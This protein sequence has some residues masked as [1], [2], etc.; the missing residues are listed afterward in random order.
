MHNGFLRALQFNSLPKSRLGGAGLQYYV[1]GAI[2]L[3]MVLAKQTNPTPYTL[4]PPH[5]VSL[6]N[7]TLNVEFDSKD[8]I[9]I[10]LGYRQTHSWAS[11]SN[12]VLRNLA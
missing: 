1:I 6:T 5:L 7:R 3:D 12:R 8:G 9:K 11:Q 2:E 4:L 10:K